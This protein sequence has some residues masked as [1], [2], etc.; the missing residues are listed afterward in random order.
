MRID[1]KERY[2]YRLLNDV[3]AGLGEADRRAQLRGAGQDFQKD[4]A[5]AVE[6]GL[7]RIGYVEARRGLWGVWYK[8]KL[9]IDNPFQERKKFEASAGLGFYFP[10]GSEVPR[11]LLWRVGAGELAFTADEFQNAA[12]AVS[13]HIVE[14]GPRGRRVAAGGAAGAVAGASG[15]G[16]TLGE[17]GL[18][19]IAG[20]AAG[21]LGVIGSAIYEFRRDSIE[22]RRIPDLD[23]YKVDRTASELLGNLRDHLDRTATLLELGRRVEGVKL[24]VIA[25]LQETDPLIRAQAGARLV[26][27]SN[28]KEGSERESTAL[29]KM[30]KMILVQQQFA[31]QRRA[32]QDRMRAIAGGTDLVH[33]AIT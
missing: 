18:A 13:E 30:A 10:T 33:D 8:D 27:R 29:G 3:W 20:A 22:A 17:P 7:S 14:G 24:E 28:G 9:V 1:A 25:L 31:E 16:M 2:T 32:V 5:T 4:E 19:V 21:V 12:K 26:E 6:I 23:S 15:A 11:H